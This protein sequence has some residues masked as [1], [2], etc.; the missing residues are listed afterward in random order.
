[1]KKSSLK[2]ICRA[3][4]F[5]LLISLLPDWAQAQVTSEELI[6]G[7]EEYIVWTLMGLEVLLLMVVVVLLIVIKTDEQ[8]ALSPHRSGGH[9]ELVEPAKP[10]YQRMLTTVNDAVP[11]EREAEVTYLHEYD[12]IYELDNDL[13]PW[14]KGLFY[15]TIAFGVVYLL[16]FHV[17]D[18]GCLSGGRIRAGD[19]RGQDRRGRLPGH[20]GC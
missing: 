4:A 11:L 7:W 5:G 12:G 9:G 1:M 18:L 8:R 16:Y 15:A 6:T 20:R 19:G 17:F 3:L 14:W 10:W 13:P 2:I